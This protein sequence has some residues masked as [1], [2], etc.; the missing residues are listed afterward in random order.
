MNKTYGFYK[1]FNNKKDLEN[2]SFCQNT[3]VKLVLI[4]IT[5]ILSIFFWY[6]N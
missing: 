1:L 6:K 2:D 4:K 5:K 3:N